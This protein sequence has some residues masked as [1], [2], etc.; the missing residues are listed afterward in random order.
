M[1]VGE[2]SRKQYLNTP[3]IL[4]KKVYIGVI[5]TLVRLPQKCLS[6]ELEM[7]CVLLG[8]SR[9]CIDGIR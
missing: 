3:Y 7:D 2:L 5:N 8:S 6:I 9:Y 4:E 1:Q